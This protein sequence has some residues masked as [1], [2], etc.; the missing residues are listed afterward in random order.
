MRTK[1]AEFELSQ[2]QTSLLVFLESYNQSIPKGFPRAS[3]ATLEKFQGLYPTLFKHGNTWSVARH[4]KKL[5]DW[6]SYRRILS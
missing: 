1:N 2:I 3:V 5:I 6:F 4:R